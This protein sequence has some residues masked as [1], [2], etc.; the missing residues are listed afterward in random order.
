[1]TAGIV[2]GLMVGA[3]LTGILSAAGITLRP[4][5]PMPIHPALVVLAL[6]AGAALFGLIGLAAAVP[7]VIVAEALAGPLTAILDDGRVDRTPRPELARP[8]RSMELAWAGGVRPGAVAIQ[9]AVSIPGVTVPVVLSLDARRDPQPAV[10]ALQ[11]RGFGRGQAALATTVLS[12]VVVIACA[13]VAALAIGGPVAETTDC[14][15]GW[16]APSGGG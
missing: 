5:R 11:A 3:L 4:Q 12:A 2:L 7:A 14:R 8:P 6:P 16:R 1:M 10:I 9:A 13:A 15:C